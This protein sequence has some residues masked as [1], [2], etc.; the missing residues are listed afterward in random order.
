MTP[1]TPCSVHGDIYIERPLYRVHKFLSQILVANSRQI[2]IAH[3]ERKER[4]EGAKW[5]GHQRRGSEEL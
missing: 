4:W 1:L 5:E 2:R 3:K